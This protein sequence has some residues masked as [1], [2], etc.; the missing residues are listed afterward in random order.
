[1][2]I[3]RVSA[4]LDLG[5]EPECSREVHSKKSKRKDNEDEV[6]VEEIIRGI[7]SSSDGKRVTG[8]YTDILV[9]IN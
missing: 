5:T 2:P 9:C 6:Y 1:M 3:Q 7:R 4:K 8:Q